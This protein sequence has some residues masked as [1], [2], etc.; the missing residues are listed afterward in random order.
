MGWG[1]SCCT[2]IGMSN[3]HSAAMIPDI[4]VIAIIKFSLKPMAVDTCTH[5]SVHSGNSHIFNYGT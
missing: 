3:F 1:K 2:A 4:T 5:H